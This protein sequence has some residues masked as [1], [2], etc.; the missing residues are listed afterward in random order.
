MNITA[1]ANDFRLPRPL[2][3]TTYGSPTILVEGLS[4]A[5]K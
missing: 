2:G 5:G 1:M 3:M 4:V